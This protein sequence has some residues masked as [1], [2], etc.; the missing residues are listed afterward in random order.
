MRRTS[1]TWKCRS[2]PSGETLPNPASEKPLTGRLGLDHVLSRCGTCPDRRKK[3]SSGASA[4]SAPGDPSGHRMRGA[5]A[6]W[7]ERRCGEISLWL[8]LWRPTWLTSWSSW[9]LPKWFTSR[10][11][12]AAL[13]AT[14]ALSSPAWSA[15]VY[16]DS[17]PDARVTFFSGVGPLTEIGNTRPGGHDG[18]DGVAHDSSALT[19]PIAPALAS[20]HELSLVDAKARRCSSRDAPPPCGNG[21][22]PLHCI[23]T[24]R[25]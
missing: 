11:Q 21:M 14:L 19:R 16:D 12:T 20:R 8:S 25:P 5:L 4:R 22:S 3:P 15:Q 24:R 23:L 7:T 6:T 1:S 10:F 13:L 2:T 17:K 18:R 9:W